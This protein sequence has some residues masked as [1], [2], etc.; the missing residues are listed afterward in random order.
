MNQKLIILKIEELVKNEFKDESSGHDWWHSHRVRQIGL[1][2][3]I[4]E[5]AD[6]FIVEASAL[7]HDVADYKFY[8]G[9]EELGSKIIKTW[10]VHLG[11]SHK[12]INQILN[13]VTN[14]SYMK[15]IKNKI[16]S[17]TH[18]LT[19]EAKVLN[20]SD[21]LDAMGAIGIARTFA[22][23]GCFK[24]EIHNPTIP[25][26]VDITYEEYKMKHSTS[27]NHFYEKLLLLKDTML[28]KK[29]KKIAQERHDFM[30]VYLNR[31]FEEWEGIK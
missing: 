8:E 5:G 20:D 14:I 27:V 10:L 19:I 28:T 31:F 22:F 6:L 25:P 13:I 12:Q 30:T 26:K 7:L 15:S 9:D 17:M 24:R 1:D 2:I 3:G 4:D 16:T 18:N 29:G 11:V 23:G 21:R